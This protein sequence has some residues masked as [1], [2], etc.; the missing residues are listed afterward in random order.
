MFKGNKN[1][2]FGFVGFR[3]PKSASDAIE[4]FDK[5]FIGTS[6]IK[7][8]YALL[9]GD[10]KLKSRKKGGQETSKKIE[11]TP[12]DALKNRLFVK[13]IPFDIVEDELREVFEE[14]GELK[15]C[16]ITRNSEQQS[17]GFGFVGFVEDISAA[18]AFENLHN[19]SKF[20]Y[21]E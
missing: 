7:V 4:Q 6:K 11:T 18:K 17:R 10:K 21:M 15:E 9:R 2:G 16:I 13:N 1:R 3:D 19:K 12:S 8:K 20:I 5:T 14:F